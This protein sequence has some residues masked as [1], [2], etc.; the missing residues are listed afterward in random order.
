MPSQSRKEE[1]A[2]RRE[3]AGLGYKVA[4]RLTLLAAAL[5][6]FVSMWAFHALPYIHDV[7][8]TS[9]GCASEGS[10]FSSFTVAPGSRPLLRC[11]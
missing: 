2:I 11:I 1:L 9:P 8:G 6:G 4:L 10:S 7:G 3:E 5:G